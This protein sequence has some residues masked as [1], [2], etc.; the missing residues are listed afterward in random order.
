[1]TSNFNDR[2]T[3]RLGAVCRTDVSPLEAFAARNGGW[4]RS[5]GVCRTILRADRA[6]RE[7]NDWWS[8]QLGLPDSDPYGQ[9][10]AES[11]RERQSL[12][13]NHR[14]RDATYTAVEALQSTSY[15]ASIRIQISDFCRVGRL[16]ESA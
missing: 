12:L 4:A 13:P 10:P 8:T 15:A 11:T 1:M 2:S 5:G 9:Q 14:N 3:P 7:L 16:R 6:I